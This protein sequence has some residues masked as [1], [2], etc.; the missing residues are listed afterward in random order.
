MPAVPLVWWSSSKV[1]CDS[2][3]GLVSKVVIPS[4]VFMPAWCSEP[5]SAWSAAPLLPRFRTGLT[6]ISPFKP[7]LAGSVSALALTAAD[8]SVSETAVPSVQLTSRSGSCVS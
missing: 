8:S 3:F 4:W 2:R 5:P 6:W 7:G 1:A